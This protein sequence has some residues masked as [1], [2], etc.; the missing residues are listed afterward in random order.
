MTVHGEREM[1]PMVS[2]AEGT[3]ALTHF[4]ETFN[5]VNRQ[6]DP[7]LNPSFE[8]ERCSPSTRPG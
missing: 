8:G 7:A 2:K 5:K 1:L 4:T 6:L 3:K